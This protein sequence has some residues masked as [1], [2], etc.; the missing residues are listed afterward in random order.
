MQP[1][2][3]VLLSGRAE[4]ARNSKA[5]CQTGLDAIPNTGLA[6]HSAGET[7]SQAVAILVGK[8]GIGNTQQYERELALIRQAG[9]KSRL[10]TAGRFRTYP[11]PHATCAHRRRCN[12]VASRGYSR[13]QADLGE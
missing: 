2:T 6:G 4:S 3:W 10:L 13:R 8:H 7:K 12:S 11:A 9:D 1:N 5:F